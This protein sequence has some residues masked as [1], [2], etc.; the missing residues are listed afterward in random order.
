MKKTLSPGPAFEP[1][2][3]YYDLIHDGLPGDREFYLEHAFRIG[4]DVLELGVGSGRLAL[5]MAALGL[6]VTGVDDSQAMLASCREKVRQMKKN[7]SRITL[8]KSDI[9]KLN[10]GKTFSCVTMPY[11]TFMHFLTRE[12]QRGAL[13]AVKRHLSDEGE[14]LFDTWNPSSRII[15]SL[16]KRSVQKHLLEGVYALP[17][18][19]RKLA[20]YCRTT[21][22]SARQRLVEEHVFHECNAHGAVLR[23]T[24]LPLVRRWTLPDELDKLVR[25]CGFEVINVFGDFNESALTKDS[26]E[27]IWRLRKARRR[28]SRLSS[29]LWPLLVLSPLSFFLDE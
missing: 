24:I 21:C 14:F 6:H 23:E 8:V 28:T 22:D 3:E 18:L 10:L 20:H 15:Q 5:P 19:R 17:G 26:V 13:L 12:E 29:V 7:R 1:W 9:V 11:R 4:G 2:A 25:L 16:E 27:M